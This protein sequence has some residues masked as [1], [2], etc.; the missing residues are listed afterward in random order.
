M[1]AVQTAERPSRRMLERQGM[2]PE[3]ELELLIIEQQADDTYRISRPMHEISFD[4]PAP[5]STEGTVTDVVGVE[6]DFAGLADGDYDDPKIVS[7]L[8]REETNISSSN[9]PH[10]TTGGYRNH[11]CRCVPCT[12]AQRKAVAEYRA[13]RSAQS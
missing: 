1:S 7:F 3:Q 2:T 12:S 11:K 8:P 6:Y 10:G 9:V 4:A 5:G 13:R